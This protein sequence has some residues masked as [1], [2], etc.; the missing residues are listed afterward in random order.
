MENSICIH[1][2]FSRSLSR[3]Y[4]CIYLCKNFPLFSLYGF[5]KIFLTFFFFSSKGGDVGTQNDIFRLIV[6]LPEVGY[7][8]VAGSGTRPPRGVGFGS[9]RRVWPIICMSPRHTQAGH[10]KT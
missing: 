6:L 4:I 3:E 2:H 5:K 9:G 10:M 8:G 1:I 7:G